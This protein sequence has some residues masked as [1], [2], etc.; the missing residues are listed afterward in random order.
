[1]PEFAIPPENVEISLSVLG[2]KAS[3]PT[4][5]PSWPAVIL[6]VLLTPPANVANVTVSKENV[7]PSA[8]SPT[9]MPL[10]P[11]VITPLLVMPPEKV[12]SLMVSPLKCPTMPPTRMPVVAAEI[13][14]KLL[15]PPEKFDSR[16][17][18]LVPVAVRP[19]KTPYLPDSVPALLMPPANGWR[20]ST[21]TTVPPL[22]A[23]LL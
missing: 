14:P 8:P 23:S 20:S 9:L 22:M 1:M 7:R 3:A 13:V 21:R 6:P 17:V 16:T 5:M 18:A 12:D 19:T 15:M 4:L 10:L 2:P 11:A